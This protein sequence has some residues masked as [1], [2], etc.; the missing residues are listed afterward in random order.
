MSGRSPPLGANRGFA[1]A[2]FSNA[3][4]NAPPLLQIPILNSSPLSHTRI[5]TTVPMIE[6]FKQS[7]GH[8]PTHLGELSGYPA[9]LIDAELSYSLSENGY[10]IILLYTP[11]WPTPGRSTCTYIA[12]DRDWTC[13]GFI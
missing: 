13:G 12:P 10:S 4:G 11:S 2:V 3:E 7:Q 8:Y 6:E 5:Y 1:W 9:D